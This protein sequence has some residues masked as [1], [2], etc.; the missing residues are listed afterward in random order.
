MQG[1]FEHKNEELFHKEAHDYHGGGP[2]E[3]VG[4]FEIDFCK[5]EL[6]A[7]GIFRS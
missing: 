2:G 3:E 1:F 7:D 6:R 5:I 4:V